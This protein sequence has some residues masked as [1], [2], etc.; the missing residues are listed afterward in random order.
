[1]HSEIKRLI[2]LDNLIRPVDKKTKILKNTIKISYFASSPG[3]T[4][5]FPGMV[6]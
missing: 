1:M 5:S 3:I 2:L 4:I 6:S